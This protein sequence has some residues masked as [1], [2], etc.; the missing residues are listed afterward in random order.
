MHGGCHAWLLLVR[1]D[2][3]TSE[4]IQHIGARAECLASAVTNKSMATSRSNLCTHASRCLSVHR[5]SELHCSCIW[6]A[7][8]TMHM[9]RSDGCS[10]RVRS[11][12][13]CAQC[14]RK[15]ECMSHARARRALGV[16]ELAGRDGQVKGPA[17]CT[18]RMSRRSR[19]RGRFLRPSPT[20]AN[21]VSARISEVHSAALHRL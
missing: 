16:A 21:C 17:C 5:R 10:G 12:A 1:A 8:W 15:V 9:C 19:R 11:V 3:P 2:A 20:R 18:V 13:V 4:L 6:R 14:W 7:L